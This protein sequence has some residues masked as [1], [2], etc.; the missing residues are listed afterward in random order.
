MDPIR[1]FSL[2]LVV[3]GDCTVDEL[4]AA[5]VRDPIVGFGG[6][7]DS[8][9]SKGVRP[10]VRCTFMLYVYANGGCMKES[11]LSWC[12]DRKCLSRVTSVLLKLS[13]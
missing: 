10:V 3:V 2:F 4:S 11:H 1:A 9:R 5:S 6:C 13:T 7:R 8:T 12:S